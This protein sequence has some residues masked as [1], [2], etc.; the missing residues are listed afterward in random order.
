MCVHVWSTLIGL[1]WLFMVLNSGRNSTSSLGFS[2]FWTA[3]VAKG[4]LSA[5]SHHLQFALC[6]VKK[7]NQVKS[8]L[9]HV[10]SKLWFFIRNVFSCLYFGANFQN[11]VLISFC[12][13]LSWWKILGSEKRII[14]TKWCFQNWFVGSDVSF[15]NWNLF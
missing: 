10:F 5:L 11:L 3:G 15:S 8:E 12:I 14:C 7:Q 6:R 9:S 2:C 1:I 13:S 4:F